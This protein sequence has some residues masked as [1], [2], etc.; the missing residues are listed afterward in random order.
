MSIMGE[1]HFLKKP[2][3]QDGFLRN[4]FSGLSYDPSAGK[5]SN[6]YMSTVK[7]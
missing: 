3:L 5:R 6:K 1:T 4:Q 7:S 2:D